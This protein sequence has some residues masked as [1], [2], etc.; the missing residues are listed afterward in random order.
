MPLSTMDKSLRQKMKGTLNLNHILDQMDLTDIYHQQ[1]HHAAS[2]A[3]YTWNIFHV[4]SYV[5]AQN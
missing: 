3:E 4:R 5:R 2:P 1:N